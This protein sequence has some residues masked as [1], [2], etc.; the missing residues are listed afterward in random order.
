MLEDPSQANLWLQLEQTSRGD[1]ERESPSTTPSPAGRPSPSLRPRPAVSIR[2]TSPPAP[3]KQH[4]IRPGTPRPIQRRFHP[5]G[6]SKADAVLQDQLAELQALVDDGQVEAVLE[7]LGL[8]VVEPLAARLPAAA[9]YRLGHWAYEQE[10]F[11]VAAPT[12]A[13]VVAAGE[14]AGD[15]LPW[16]ELFLA[17]SCRGLGEISRAHEQLVGVL[18]V[19]PGHDAAFHAQVA[20]AWLD[21]NAGAS[22]SATD[23]LAQLR[24][25]PQAGS[26]LADLDLLGRV[27]STL[28]W[29]TTNPRDQISHAVDRASS[30]GVVAAIDAF[31]L[32]RCGRLMLLQGWLV[33]PGQQLREL[34][35]VRGERAWRLNLRQAR[36]TNRPDLA[37][38]VARCGGDTNLHAGFSLTQIALAEEAVPLQPGEAAELFAVLANGVQFCLRRTL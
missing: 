36:Y 19:H 22:A 23:A 34:C 9:A 12:L 8:D 27:L 17:L 32:S 6:S 16:A 30:D 5:V 18:A 2:T 14:Q 38:V 28:E 20:L 24:K 13:V 7:R 10:R 21:L 31:R 29:L 4:G 37:E 33:D 1:K 3:A 15:L 35:L 26:H 11:E 25:H